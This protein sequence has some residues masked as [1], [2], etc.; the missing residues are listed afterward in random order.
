MTEDSTAPTA[1]AGPGDR[2]RPPV[3]FPT[4]L[5]GQPALVTGA[6]SGIGR[7][8][9]L[10]LAAS[11][12][13]VVINYVV[14][15]AA[16]EEVANRIETL[17]RKAITIKADVSDEEAVR[18]MFTRAVDHFGTLHI[19]VSNAGLQRD[20]Q[21]GKFHRRGDGAVG[22]EHV[23][24]PD[25]LGNTD[26]QSLQ[27]VGGIDQ[28]LVIGDVAKA[29]LVDGDDFIALGLGLRRH[30]LPEHLIEEAL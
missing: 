6:N 16:A 8:V 26:F 13:D 23:L 4:V 1:P 12:A 9:A 19:L 27:I 3:R 14:N 18:A 17:G 10:G 28:P 7:A 29:V 21:F 5:E 30:V 24:A 22:L 2:P 11:G 20:E 15:P 25:A